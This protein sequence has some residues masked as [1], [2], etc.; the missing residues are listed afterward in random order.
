MTILKAHDDH[1]QEWGVG[2][3]DFVSISS[4][5]GTVQVEQCVDCGF[6]KVMCLHERNTWTDDHQHLNCNLCGLD[7]T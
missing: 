2:A 7:V 6:Y 3:A 1:V 4:D 5:L